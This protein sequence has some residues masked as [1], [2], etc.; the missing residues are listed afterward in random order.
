MG[1]IF[2]DAGGMLLRSI[3]SM[4]LNLTAMAIDLLVPPLALLALI[5]A[6]VFAII[7]SVVWY[8]DSG[9]V[10]LYMLLL[11][12]ALLFAALLITW[13][14]FARRVISVRELF[15]IP[16]YICSKIPIYVGYWLKR[17]TEWIRTP[18]D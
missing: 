17:Q 8:Y 13:Y 15:S 3:G 10:A 2:S 18:R 12:S 9:W 14:R 6:A 7:A 4:N 1:V 11:I 16:L 5:L